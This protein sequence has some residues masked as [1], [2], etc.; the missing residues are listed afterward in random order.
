MEIDPALLPPLY[1]SCQV[2]GRITAQAA[3]ATGLIP[4]TPV[5]AGAGDNAAAAV[6]TGVVEAGKAFTTLGTSG[7]VFAHADQVTIDPQGRVHTFCSAVP[8]AWAVM[9]CTLSAG[10]SLK[11]LRDNFCPQER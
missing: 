6:G 11:W 2:A 3:A 1:E 5:V 10:G 8:G 4:G 9:S 7:V